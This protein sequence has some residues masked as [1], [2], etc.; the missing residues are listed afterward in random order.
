M[1]YIFNPKKWS[2][3]EN[4][5]NAFLAYTFS[6]EKIFFHGISPPSPVLSPRSRVGF[7]LLTFTQLSPVEYSGPEE[8]L[9]KAFS[10]YC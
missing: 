1:Y 8:M 6:S 5:K 3:L 7:L 2:G 10:I 9:F 4:C